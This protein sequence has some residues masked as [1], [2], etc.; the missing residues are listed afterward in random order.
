MYLDYF[1]YDSEEKMRRFWDHNQ[2]HIRTL[3]PG[4]NHPSFTKLMNEYL[5]LKPND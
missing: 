2:Q 3:L 1:R 5:E 4:E